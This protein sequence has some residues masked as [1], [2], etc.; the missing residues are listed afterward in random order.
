MFSD[1]G[2]SRV[3]ALTYRIVATK[4]EMVWEKSGPVE[5]GLAGLAATAL[6]SITLE[7]IAVVLTSYIMKL[8]GAAYVS[9]LNTAGF[10]TE[11][12]F[13]CEG[14]SSERVSG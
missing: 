11:F 13:C 12:K 6:K 4:L 8:Q 9:L 7:C 2:N 5:T 14:E 3:N 1:V 10:I